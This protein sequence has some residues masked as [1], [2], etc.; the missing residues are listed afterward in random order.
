MPATNSILLDI[1]CAAVP[2]DLCTG[3]WTGGSPSGVHA[4]PTT[5]VDVTPTGHK[6]SSI[7]PSAIEK[8]GSQL[9]PKSVV[10]ILRTPCVHV[11]RFPR[12][13]AWS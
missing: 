4:K 7:G 10:R 9:P 11:R 6:T 8:A 5:F 12:G 3:R 1:G 13:S 2:H